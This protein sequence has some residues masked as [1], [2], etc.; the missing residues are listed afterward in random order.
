MSRDVGAVLS[1]RT[2]GQQVR[3]LKLGR[4]YSARGLISEADAGG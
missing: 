1:E 3:W 2:N 4:F